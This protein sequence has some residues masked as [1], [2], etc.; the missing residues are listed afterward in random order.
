MR[1]W[2]ASIAAFG[3]VRLAFDPI[4]SELAPAMLL[5]EEGG[6]N[7]SLAPSDLGALSDR[8]DFLL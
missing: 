8:P 4:E 6:A 1:S 5:R 3:P 7:R 2:T